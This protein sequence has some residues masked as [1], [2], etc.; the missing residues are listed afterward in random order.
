MKVGSHTIEPSNEDKV[1]FPESRITKGDLVHY[2]RDIAPIML[3][4]VQD[5][6]VTMHRFPDGIEGEGFYQKEVPEYFPQWVDRVRISKKEGGENQQAV[7]NNAATLVYLADQACITPHIWL[8][9]TDRLNHPDKL[10]FDLDP[11]PDAFELVRK[12]AYGLKDV[13]K[14]IGL[15]P[16][17]MTTG[18]RGVHVVAPL[19]RSQEFDTVRT[20]AENLADS[21][22]QED[23][24]N[25]TTEQ[26]KAKRGSRVFL[27]I[28]RNSYAQTSVAPY[29]VRAKPGAPVATPLEWRELEDVTSQSYTITTVLERMSQ[30]SDP[31]KSLYSEARPLPQL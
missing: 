9:R 8:S 15:T 26:R 12:A 30:K 1:F 23:P 5:R 17:V 25:L 14:E 27:D 21:L 11:P 7:C 29:A 28:M 3:P 2:Y 6:P 22:F 4:H 10:V 19:D 13:L 20:F 16:F 24:Q 31:W 18:S